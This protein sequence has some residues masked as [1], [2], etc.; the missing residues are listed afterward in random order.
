MEFH[1]T[2]AAI[3]NKSHR[4]RHPEYGRPVR[5]YG[6]RDLE[7]VPGVPDLQFKRE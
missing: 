4:L 6:Y 5:L 2:L 3:A 7:V 1:E